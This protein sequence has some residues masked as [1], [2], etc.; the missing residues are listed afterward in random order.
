LPLAEG[1]GYCGPRRFGETLGYPGPAKV[2]ARALDRSAAARLRDA[3]ESLTGLR[4][5][6]SSDRRRQQAST[7]GSA[8]AIETSVAQARM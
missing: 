1:G 5:G 7:A 6:E 2:P 4:S 3:S 8:S